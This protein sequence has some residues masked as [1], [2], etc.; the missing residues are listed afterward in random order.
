M[1][2]STF[3]ASIRRYML[4]GSGMCFVLSC[5]LHSASAGL[6]PPIVE[7]THTCPRKLLV[8]R[9][10]RAVIA[11]QLKENE[12]CLVKRSQGLLYLIRTRHLVQSE[13]VSVETLTR[14]W[15]GRTSCGY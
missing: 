14:K 3:L 7:H 6:A 12:V 9:S 13:P 8:G 11:H 5:H 10:L 15:M 1:T 4:Q 2:V